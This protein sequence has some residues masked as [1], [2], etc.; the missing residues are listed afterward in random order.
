MLDLV[1]HSKECW[2]LVFE[3]GG[4]TIT[5]IQGM[6]FIKGLGIYSLGLFFRHITD[7]VEKWTPN[8]AAISLSVRPSA[9]SALISSR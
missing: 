9:F 5:R 3:R 6:W 1:T 4:Q 2:G 7:T 8:I